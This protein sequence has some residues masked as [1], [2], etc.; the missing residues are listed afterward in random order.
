MKEMFTLPFEP[1]TIFS[2]LFPLYHFLQG[3]ASHFHLNNT[4]IRDVP[5]TNSGEYDT[6]IHTNLMI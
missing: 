6:S 4:D 2:K 5:L 1:G 3:N